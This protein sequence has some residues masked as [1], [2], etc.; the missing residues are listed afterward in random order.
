[1]MLQK[2]L[3]SSPNYFI[4]SVFNEAI[5][6]RQTGLVEVMLAMWTQLLLRGHSDN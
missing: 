4:K 1:M 6:R 2:Y 5:A 3:N